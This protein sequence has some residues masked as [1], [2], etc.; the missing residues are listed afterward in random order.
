MNDLPPI[1]KTLADGYTLQIR[2]TFKL[3]LFASTATVIVLTSPGDNA[4]ITFFGLAIPSSDFFPICAILLWLLYISFCASH[5]QCLMVGELYQSLVNDTLRNRQCYPGSRVRM[6]DIAH[7][8]YQPGIIRLFPITHYVPQWARGTYYRWVKVLYD[9]AYLTFPAF[10]WIICLKEIK[11]ATE[12]LR[13][14]VFIF[15]FVVTLSFWLPI[16]VRQA[17][18]IAEFWRSKRLIRAAAE[19]RPESPRVMEGKGAGGNS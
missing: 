8:L 4:T 6:S 11:F 9:F 14:L 16:I 15:A 5:A 2:H 17:R 18:W 19:E 10:G 1:L 12:R 7:M 3:W 13:T